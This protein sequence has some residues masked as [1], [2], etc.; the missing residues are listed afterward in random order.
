MTHDELLRM[1]VNHEDNF[2]ERKPEHA[3]SAELRQTLGAFAN[4]VPEGRNAVL[5]I[6]IH[7]RTGEVLGVTDPDQLQKRVSSVCQ[8]DCYPP[9][10]HTSEVLTASNG[11][12]VLAVVIPPSNAKPHFT[13]PAYVRVGS[14]SR[15]ASEEQYEVLI[16]SRNDKAREILKHKN[17]VFTVLGINYKLGSNKP[18]AGGNY[19]ESCKCRIEECTAHMVTLID[20]GSRRHFSEPLEHIKFNYDHDNQCPML[21]C[22]SR[23]LI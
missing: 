13:G 4:T 23:D 8:S 20:I 11:K 17:E 21:M 22:P 18:L 6:G 5:F 10:A 15:K 14:E 9:I 12:L 3:K 2:V 1:I 7:D 19:R 16:L